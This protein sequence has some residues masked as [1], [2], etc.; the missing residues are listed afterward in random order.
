MAKTEQTNGKAKRIA[1]A[2]ALAAKP[3]EAVHGQGRA[4]KRETV[5]ALRKELQQELAWQAAKQ[6]EE[7]QKL[8][9]KDLA[10]ARKHM[11]KFMNV[12]HGQWLTR[13]ELRELRK[14]IHDSKANKDL[15]F[16]DW[17]EGIDGA[18]LWHETKKGAA[19]W[20]AVCQRLEAVA[21]MKALEEAEGKAQE[22][23]Q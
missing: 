13:E 12:G 20:D 8:H 23:E 14:V 1:K 5:L 6:A 21:A 22:Q 16:T 9:D 11:P 4:A 10:Y 18:F 15:Q 3:K 19:Y 7:K 17:P 2:Q